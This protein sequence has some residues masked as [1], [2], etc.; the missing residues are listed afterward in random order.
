MTSV[1]Q[2]NSESQEGQMGQVWEEQLFNKCTRESGARHIIHGTH[3]AAAPTPP[4]EHEQI[5]SLPP[6]LDKLSTSFL[7]G[8]SLL[9][10]DVNVRC[11]RTQYI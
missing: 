4:G 8:T 3:R 6:P 7:Y 1:F 10:D 2:L 9:T 5:L 11:L